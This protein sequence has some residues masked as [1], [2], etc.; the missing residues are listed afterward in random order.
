[1]GCDMLVAL[2][3]ATAQQHTLFGI[4][5]FS[6]R[7]SHP[8]VV[9]LPAAT[10]SPDE[11]VFTPHGALPQVRHTCAV[12]GLQPKGAW[13]LSHGCNDHRVAMGLAHWRCRPTHPEPG[14]T[15]DDLVRL[16][17]E[18]SHSAVHA[19]DVLTDL[20][21]RHRHGGEQGAPGS[22][23][24]IADAQEAYVVEAAGNCWA[25][26][27]C[28]QSR[29]V[30]DVA[31]IRQDWQRLSPGLAEHAIESGWWRDDGTK[32]D[33]AGSLGQQG[34]TDA[35]ALRR[36]GRATLTLAQHSGGLHPE[37]M[38][39]LLVDHFDATGRKHEL[40][41]A[42]NLHTAS[43][44]LCLDAADGALA[45]HASGPATAPVFFPLVLDA[46]LPEGWRTRPPVLDT[47][48]SQRELAS[49]AAAHLQRQFDQDTEEYLEAARRLKE[50]GDG[51]AVRR[52]AH[53]MMQK[54]LE[55][56]H[57]EFDFS[58]AKPP[59]AAAARAHSE[60]EELAPFAFG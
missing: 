5:L 32:I 43:M 20:I 35:W 42:K 26:Q 11:A 54:H 57:E 59:V 53:A 6:T 39:Q 4:N 13:G 12:L 49:D 58:P 2:G 47:A 18:R 23:F 45:W 16:T 9:G 36:W 3:P 1:M 44:V 10:H 46:E 24:L 31:L 51:A 34:E 41:P 30:A 28:Q 8:A 29:A 56:W 38:R 25:L 48:R 22:V 40:A 37:A 27:D 21:A 60:D 14:L 55:R 52:L 7:R 33:F 17:L 50:R 15:G 19:V